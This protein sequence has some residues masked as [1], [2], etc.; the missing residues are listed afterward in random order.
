MSSERSFTGRVRP[1]RGLG[2]KRMADPSI[3]AGME[4]V[5]GF[6]VVPGTLNALLDHPFGQPAGTFH[7]AAE[8]VA[9]DW[10]ASTGQGSRTHDR[11]DATPRSAP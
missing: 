11:N 4:A 1:G 6:E 7:V 10:S 3:L 2:A 5:A 9:D 8:D